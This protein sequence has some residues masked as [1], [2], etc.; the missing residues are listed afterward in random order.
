MI[1][2]IL[3]PGGFDIFVK[4]MDSLTID[5]QTQVFNAMSGQVRN[6]PRRRV[7]P[8]QKARDVANARS[9]RARG[10]DYDASLLD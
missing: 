3:T 2:Q 4:M 10:L 9:H 8:Q 5:E 6:A 7:D 1:D